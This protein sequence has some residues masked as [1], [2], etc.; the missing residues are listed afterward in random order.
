MEPGEGPEQEDA[1]RVYYRSL[2]RLGSFVVQFSEK[3]VALLDQIEPIFAEER[4]PEIVRK[5]LKSNLRI[6][7]IENADEPLFDACFFS[8]K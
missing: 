4:V 1:R 8:K 3:S 2:M 6:G 7:L 5:V